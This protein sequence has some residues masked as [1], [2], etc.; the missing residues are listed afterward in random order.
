[1][2]FRPWP[3]HRLL[4][5]KSTLIKHRLELMAKTMRSHP[6]SPFLL[7]EP[8]CWTTLIFLKIWTQNGLTFSSFSNLPTSEK[9]T[10]QRKQNACGPSL[11]IR[12]LSTFHFLYCIYNHFSIF[13]WKIN[14]LKL[15]SYFNYFVYLR[16]KYR[17]PQ[18]IIVS[19]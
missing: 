12:F 14:F 7:P 17:R 3:K 19:K 11:H 5:F 13:F 2:V 9:T 10:S 6:T 15:L 1:M 16:F 8:I 4:I 18:I